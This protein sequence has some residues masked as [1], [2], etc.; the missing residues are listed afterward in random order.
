[1]LF[2][3]LALLGLT[4]ADNVADAGPK[5]F[6]PVDMLSTPRP[7]AA[8]AAPDGLHAISVVDQWNE[9]DDT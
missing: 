8:I 9:K 6:T 7:Q 1:M 3:L 4:A 2:P 5:Q